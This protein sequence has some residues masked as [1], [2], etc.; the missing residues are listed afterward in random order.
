[1]ASITLPRSP[2]SL[3]SGDE[4]PHI[5]TRKS[6]LRPNEFLI[7]SAK[8]LLRQNRHTAAMSQRSA[9]S[10]RKQTCRPR[11]WSKC[12]HQSAQQTK[13]LRCLP[14]VCDCFRRISADRLDVG[15]DV[16]HYHTKV[17]QCTQIKSAQRGEEFV[18]L[19][20]R[21]AYLT[22]YITSTLEIRVGKNRTVHLN[23]NGPAF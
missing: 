10:R 11:S 14:A 6:R 13:S 17:N 19:R 8:R 5:F 12:C 22:D 2:V 21:R 23:K 20:L 3:S 1:M 16:R 4:V 7:S 9:R 18:Y 15:H